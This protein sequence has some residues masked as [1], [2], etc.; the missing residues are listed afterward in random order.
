MRLTLTLLFSLLFSLPGLTQTGSYYMAQYNLEERGISNYNFDIAQDNRGLIY[1]ANLKGVIVSDGLDWSLIETPYSV[2]SLDFDTENNLYVGGRKEIGV[3]SNPNSLL[4]SYHSISTVKQEVF[5]VKNHQNKVYFLSEATLYM[6]D[7]PSKKVAI[8]EKPSNDFFSSLVVIDNEMYV[9]SEV[10]GVQS[11]K[12]G[13]LVSARITLPNHTISVVS[14]KKGD[15]LTIT[16]EGSYFIKKAGKAKL[17][18]F[19]IDDEGYLDNNTLVSIRWVNENLLAVSTLT[20]GVIFI[21]ADT[22]RIAQFMNFENGLLDNEVLTLFVG[23]NN[24]VW[25]AT[26]QGVSIIAPEIP[27]RNYA[28]YKG[29]TG[30]VQVVYDFNNRLFVGTSVGLFELVKKS[31]FEDVISYKKRTKT[32]KVVEKEEVPTKRGLFK[33]KNK[34]TTPKTYYKKQVEKQLLSQSYEY[35][36]VESIDAKVVQLLEYDGKLLVASLSGIYELTDA[37]QTGGQEEQG[38][39]NKI[40]EQPVVYMYKPEKSSFLMVSTYNKEIKVLT[41]QKTEWAETGLLDGLKD[42]VEQIEKGDN[43]SLWLCGADSL[44]RIELSNAY[45]LD[46]VEV[47]P[48]HNPY[49]ER[50]YASEYKG[51]AYFLNSSGYYYYQDHEIKKDTQ[52]EKQIGLPKKMILSADNKLWVNTGNLW[53]G[54]GED[55]NN[56]LNFISLFEDPRFISEIDNNNFWVVA[57][58]NQVYKIDGNEIK[59]ISRRFELFLEKAQKDSIALPLTSVLG[60]IDQQSSLSFKFA[61][62]DYT[63]I[64]QTE[65]QYRLVGLSSQWSEWGRQNNEIVFPYLPA[66][67]YELEVRA[68]D[69]LGNVKNSEAINFSILAPYWKRPWFYLAELLFFGG[70]MALSVI[71]HRKK[72]KFSVLSRLLTFLTLIFIVEF[73]QTIAEAKFE[74]NQSPVI[75]FFIQVAIALSIL[76]VEGVLRKFITKRQ[77]KE[78]DKVLQEQAKLN[79]AKDA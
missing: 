29:L 12:N 63:N 3:I 21:E 26:P 64:Y 78:E 47:F 50:I 9:A 58:G 79:P 1:L 41:K 53:Y 13:A 43:G 24:V 49:L 36:K 57:G 68:R 38:K 10:K 51:K 62:P 60:A 5:E 48:I 6:Y 72:H 52:I 30:N 69:A 31:V 37:S 66:G 2:F 55:L 70:L 27:I 56:S 16:S 28:S 25:C 14:S 65:F 32:E 19:I 7:I 44:Y 18:P 67:K 74:T 23:K 20:G 54:Q 22:G 35:E 39:A 59:S 40:F 4:G 76:P 73:V 45:S 33:R 8:I 15:Q 71:I 17:V 75:N 46:D 77:Q 42:L 11:I 34:R 61:S